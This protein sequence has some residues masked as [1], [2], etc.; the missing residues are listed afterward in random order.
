V[1]IRF[2]KDKGKIGLITHN[3]FK[4]KR[5]DLVVSHSKIVISHSNS[6]LTLAPEPDKQYIY[7][8]KVIIPKTADKSLRNLLQ[9]NA[10]FTPYKKTKSNAFNT[11][12]NNI[13]FLIMNDKLVKI[14]EDLETA[15]VG[16]DVINAEFFLIYSHIST[17]NNDTVDVPYNFRTE[18]RI[19]R[20]QAYM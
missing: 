9:R 15:N 17:N 4:S 6:L 20:T 1:L 3:L 11:Y 8:K 10:S 12:G 7:L 14:Y 19:I 18:I 2:G 16:L 5:P 13:L